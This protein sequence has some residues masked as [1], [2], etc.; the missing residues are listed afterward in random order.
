MPLQHRDDKEII[1]GGWLE[2]AGLYNSITYFGN[3][4]KKLQNS[5][6][7]EKTPLLQK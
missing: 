3:I 5:F 1:V 7:E 2:V 4:S 6:Q